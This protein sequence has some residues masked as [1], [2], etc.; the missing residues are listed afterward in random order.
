MPGISLG[1]ESAGTA[2]LVSQAVVAWP[3]AQLLRGHRGRV[4]ARPAQERPEP[5]AGGA[6]ARP[7]AAGSR[8]LQTSAARATSSQTVVRWAGRVQHGASLG[9]AGRRGASRPPLGSLSRSA[10]G[11]L[12]GRRSSAHGKELDQ[13]D[14]LPAP[15]S[16]PQA[17]RRGAQGERLMPA[18][19]IRRLS[20]Y[21]TAR[22]G[23]VCARSKRAWS[24][25]VSS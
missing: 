1:A 24:A 9:A 25:L 22:W 19:R 3:V 2:M 14:G 17:V 11:R 13:E 4:P 16:P 23:R 21:E 6:S 8:A 7:C 5:D 18:R 20:Q 10:S 12:R 15:L